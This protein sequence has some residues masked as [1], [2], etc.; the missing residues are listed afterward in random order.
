MKSFN[1]F[2]TMFALLLVFLMSTACAQDGSSTT[3]KDAAKDAKDAAK[4]AKDAKDAADE[5]EEIANELATEAEEDISDEEMEKAAAKEHDEDE[6]EEEDKKK[7]KVKKVVKKPAIKKDGV[8]TIKVKKNSKVFIDNKNKGIV[9][10]NTIKNF[11][12]SAGL[13]KV[14]VQAINDNKSYV[15]GVKIQHR[16]RISLTF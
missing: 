7:K 15:K 9:K 5:A 2:G 16:K 12:L 10:A 6:V 14:K 4:D 8:L 3:A 13:H 11:F 1:M